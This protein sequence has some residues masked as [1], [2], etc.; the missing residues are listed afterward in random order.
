MKH[1]VFSFPIS[2][3]VTLFLYHFAPKIIKIHTKI[4]IFLHIPNILCNFV[5]V[6]Y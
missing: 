6:L 4:I 5:A 2:V 3:L 1:I